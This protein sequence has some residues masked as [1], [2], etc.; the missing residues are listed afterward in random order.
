[1]N[2]HHFINRELSWLEFNQR[3]L[4]EMTDPSL[5]LFERVKFASITASNM[6]E[7]FMVRVGGLQILDQ[8][9]VISTDAA[10]MTPQQQLVAIREQTRRISDVLY[11][12]FLEQIEPALAAAQIPRMTPSQLTESQQLALKQMVVEE[13]S[14]ILSPLAIDQSI[15]PPNI[16][17]KTL[18]IA[19]LIADKAHPDSGRLVFIPLAKPISRFIKIPS[20]GQHAFILVED[21]IEMFVEQFF[22]TAQVIHSTTFR[23]LRNADIAIRED[24]AHDLLLQMENMIDVRKTAACVRLEVSSNSSHQL[25]QMLQKFFAVDELNTYRSPGPLDLSA[26]FSLT[27]LGGHEDLNY[28]VWPPQA[29]PDIDL[30]ESLFETIARRDV[31]LVHPYESFEPVIR[32]LEE[33][34]S[35]P[36]VLAIKQTLYRT[37]QQSP[38]VAALVE[39]AERGKY[40][41][42]IV[43][44][45]ARFDEARNIEWARDMERAG[46]QVLYGVKGLKTHAKACMIVRREP[47]GIRRYLHFG[48]GNYNEQTARFYCDVSYFTCNEQL[49]SDVAGIFNAITGYTEPPRLEHIAMA[50]LTLRERLLEEIEAETERAG[51]GQDAIIRA[52]MNALVDPLIISALYK[53]SAAGVQ[54]DLNVRG[55]CC[56]RAGVEGLSENIRVISIVDRYL[57]H[58]RIYYFHGTGEP[59]VFLSSADWMPRNLNRRVELLVPVNDPACQDKLIEILETCL[60]DDVKSHQLMPD[61]SYDRIKTLDPDNPVRC[62]QLIYERATEQLIAAEQSKPTRFEPHRRPK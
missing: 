38:I 28:P 45:K 30:S 7:F 48:T 55:I 52:K 61:G 5:P 16:S 8:H 60:A 4:G 39:A 42:V 43:E 21:V 24:L 57:E 27:G 20:S 58:S 12:C 10:G 13:F 23:I 29:S 53:A 35:D 25:V 2:S 56:L 41:T 37:S 44:L 46:V 26:W 3:V 59:H 50:P 11:D 32:L 15:E 54:I 18:H 14:A 40:V 62:Q 9:Q 51:Q 33:A 1:M 47:Q 49:G 17:N 22:P 36:D 34:A 6:D 19:V 31:L